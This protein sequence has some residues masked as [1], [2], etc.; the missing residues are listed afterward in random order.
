MLKP[1]LCDFGDAYINVKGTI[2][3]VRQGAD[4][5]AVQGNRNNK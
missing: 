3:V 1:S 4:A 2:I 5:A